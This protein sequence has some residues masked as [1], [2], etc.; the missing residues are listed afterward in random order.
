MAQ[1]FAKHR[2]PAQKNGKRNSKKAATRVNAQSNNHWS[3]F[4]TGLLSGLFV[5]IITYVGII[6]PGVN[7]KPAVDFASQENIIPDEEEATELGFYN[8]LRD[9]EVI[10]NVVPVEIETIAV[11]EEEV[12]PVNYLLQ[13]GSF[14]IQ[15]DADN[16]RAKI[17]LLNMDANIVLAVI[18]GRTWYRV[19]AGPFIGRNGVEIAE[20]ILT[21]NGIVHMR[22]GLGRR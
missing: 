21:A 16:L 5:A 11:A 19:Q 10:V 17:I 9:A 2:P 7:V 18:A 3:W 14:Q 4:F 1:D 22:L 8:F 20:D 13:A 6:N 12:D 15:E